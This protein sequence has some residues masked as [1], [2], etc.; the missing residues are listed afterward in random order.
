MD[1]IFL[2]I[3]R[4]N[5]IISFPLNQCN[6]Y[7][8]YQCINSS[9]CILFNHLNNGIS[10]CPYNDDENIVEDTNPHLF[11]Q[12]KYKYYKC[13]IMNKYIP[14]S[15]IL[16]GDCDCGY[17]EHN[18]CEDEHEF[19]NF[20]GRTISFQTICDSFQKLY[21]ITIDGKNAIDETECEQW[22]CDNIYTHC[23]KVWDCLDG[24]DEID[25]DG[26]PSLLN[27]SSD[28]RMCVTLD[29]YQMTCLP[30]NQINDGK[31][32]CLGGTDERILCR[33]PFFNRDG[34]FYCD[35]SLGS[36]C[37][38]SD[39]LCTT[40]AWCFNREDEQF[41]QIN[42]SIPVGYSICQ[43]DYISFGSDIEKFLCNTTKYNSKPR[44]KYFKI[45]GFNQSSKD[46][47][48]KNELINIITLDDFTLLPLLDNPRCN[49]GLDLRVW[50][51]KSSNHYT[52]TCLCPPSYYVQSRQILFAILV[53]L[54]DNTTQRTIHSYEQFTYLSI[55]DCKIKFNSTCSFNS[56][57][58]DLFNNNR[59]ICV[60]QENYFGSKC[61]LRNRICDKSRC[62]N[63]GLCIPHDAFMLSTNR[64]YFCICP[65]GFNGNQCE[66]VDNQLN[67]IFDKSIHI[68][69]SIFIHFI[70]IIPFEQFE[71]TI[72]KTS[73]QRSTTFQTISQATNSIQIY[74]SQPFH[75]TFIETLDKTYY[76]SVIQSIYNHSTTIV[77]R[78]NSSH[79]CPSINELVNQTFSQLHVLRR[80]KSYH[81]ICQQYSPHLQCFH[82]DFHLCLC[83]N[84]Q[85]KKRLANCFQFDCFGQ[86][87]CENNGQCF[88][89]S[90]DCPKRSICICPSCYYGNRC[91]FSTSEFGLSLDAILAYHIIPN[92]NIF[93]QTSIV[94]ISFSLTILFMIIGLINGFLSLI[95]F[96][97]KNVLE[98]GCGIYLLSS[99]ITT[100]LIMILFE[101]KYLIYL[102]TQI[103]IPSNQLF[104]KIQCYSLDFL[105]RI[106]L[107]MDQWLNACV[108][109]ERAITII[110]ARRFVTKKSKQLAKK[111]LI[112]LLLLTILTS[113]HDPIH[114]RLFQEENENDNSKIRIWCIVNY[115]SNLQIHNRIMNTLHF[116]V[117]FLINFISSNILI[118]KRFHQ[119]VHVCNDQQF[120]KDVLHRQIREH[121]HLLI[122]PVILFILALPRLILSYLFKCMNSTKDSWIFLYGYFVSFIPTMITFFIFVLPSKFYR[123][124]S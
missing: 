88:Q 6:E 44:V 46:E 7:N 48:N 85:K 38:D 39:S 63:N 55:R 92:V 84:H 53:L 45:D 16:N 10:D 12:F 1:E 54:L 118:Q 64:K 119:K 32:D 28:Y 47:I 114:R 30:L 4:F 87:H 9:K 99:S 78:I 93:H 27:C 123:N 102:S 110:Q 57:S 19:D 75:L 56:L 68:S 94:K 13:L 5:P 66:I 113:I 124:Q 26:L 41:C 122:A 23:D 43:N 33:H 112:L 74:W 35:N 52:S 29:T 97:T 107:N 106:C 104:L 62:E 89:D 61:Y 83:Y 36:S 14:Q 69:H 70:R 31:V 82:D 51:N 101:L 117:P 3:K 25:C 24:K 72:P 105:L 91:Q 2:Q 121:Q 42:R 11:S 115:S 108:A 18:F 103:S 20:T 96:K 37:I 90:P 76:L 111:V 86:N 15:V 71:F 81:L 21:P 95:T 58:I 50:L 65:K 120:Y 67:I 17:D 98:V 109:L 49:R 34:G 116:F 80:V 60:C 59:S 73:S 77:K 79:R 8:L 22:E 100:I 40:T